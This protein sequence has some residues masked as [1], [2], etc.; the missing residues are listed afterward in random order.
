MSEQEDV[1]FTLKPGEEGW[2]EKPDGTKLGMRKLPDTEAENEQAEARVA[3]V[4]PQTV[5]PTKTRI[6]SPSTGESREAVDRAIALDAELA[7]REGRFPRSTE[8]E[9]TARVD[10]LLTILHKDAEAILRFEAEGNNRMVCSLAYAI[11][12]RTREL[13]AALEPASTEGEGE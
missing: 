2:V 7:E 4:K 12:V 11:Q 6:V 8:R 1:E 5:N 3:K 10:S 13:R 9:G